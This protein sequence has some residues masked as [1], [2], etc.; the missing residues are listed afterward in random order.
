MV[1][2]AH[3]FLLT[4]LL[5]HEFEA[6][7]RF[8]NLRTQLHTMSNLKHWASLTLKHVLVKEP[9]TER[10]TFTVL[11][12]NLPTERFNLIVSGDEPEDKLI[13]G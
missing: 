6:L 8:I 11:W 12:M 3:V 9:T 7:S 10:F 4:D 5:D 2:L 13:N 1:D